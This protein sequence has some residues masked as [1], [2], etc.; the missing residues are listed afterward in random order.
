MNLLLWVV[1]VGIGISSPVQ[2]QE[3]PA[4]PKEADR[5]FNGSSLEGWVAEGKSK[6]TEGKSGKPL[7]I[8]TVKDGCIYCAGKGYGFLRYKKEFKDFHFHLQYRFV[9][10]GGRNNSGIGIRTVPFNPKKSRATRPSFACYEIQLL[11]D[12]GRKPS[13]HSTGSL[14]RYVAPKVSAINPAPEWNT[15][16]I[17]CQGP[18]IQITMNGKEII[19][20][21]QS[22]IAR[23]KDKPL[24]GYLCLQNH[25]SQVEFRDLWVRELK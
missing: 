1:S 2:K 18:K 3:S 25:G 14:Y 12:V 8:W 21:D 23:L 5:I 22:T 19:N 20:V 10:P 6:Y 15:M 7:P 9:K 17:V 4:A 13:T 24:R 11:N 16:D